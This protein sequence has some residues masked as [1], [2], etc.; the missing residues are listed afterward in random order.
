MNKIAKT[1]ALVCSMALILFSASCSK[2]QSD[3]ESSLETASLSEVRSVT[4]DEE[5]DADKAF[6]SI[7]INGTMLPSPPCISDFG[8]GFTLG[9]KLFSGDEDSSG[10][11]VGNLLS[12]EVKSISYDIY[13][14]SYEE[15]DDDEA[16]KAVSLDVISQE[17]GDAME[18]GALLSVLGITVGDS[19]DSADKAFGTP[20]SISVAEDN[21]GTYTYTSSEDASRMISLSFEDNIVTKISIYYSVMG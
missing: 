12:N 15:Q 5:F 17:N 21:A 4:T 10:R 13:S 14:V 1:T 8:G 19:M 9:T 2:E 7:Q 16:L 6:E 3:S 18:S 20:N 11:L